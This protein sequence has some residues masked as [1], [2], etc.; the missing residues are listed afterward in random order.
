MPGVSPPI[1]DGFCGNQ[2]DPA[3]IQSVLEPIQGDIAPIQDVS[4]KI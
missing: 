3:G 2:V 4:A 1:L